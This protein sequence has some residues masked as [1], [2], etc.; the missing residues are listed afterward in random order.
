MADDV[1]I[2]PVSSTYSIDWKCADPFCLRPG[3]IKHASEPAPEPD[4]DDDLVIAQFLEGLVDGAQVLA[5][6]HDRHG[7]HVHAGMV[8]DGW[9]EAGPDSLATQCVLADGGG[10]SGDGT[11]CATAGPDSFDSDGVR[12]WHS[13]THG[14]VDRA[15]TPDAAAS[16]HGSC[17]VVGECGELPGADDGCV[18]EAGRR[19]PPLGSK[20]GC[21]VSGAT[22]GH[23]VRAGAVALAGAHV[24][25][26]CHGHQVRAGLVLGGWCEAGP[27]SL[28]T[29]C[30]LADGGGDRGDHTSC[31][32]AGPDLYDSDGV[33]SWHSVTHGVVDLACTSDAAASGHGSSAVVGDCG[34]LPGVADGCDDEAGRRAPPHGS[35][36]GCGLAGAAHGHLVHAGAVALAGAPV[37]QGH[38]AHAGMV[39]G[40]WCE[41]GP[42]S[43]DTPSV[44]V[45][46]GGNSG[47]HTS[48]ASAG[49]DSFSSDGVRSWQSVAHGV[50]DP[51]C[52]FDAAASVHGSSAVVG[53]CGELPGT[54]DGCDAVA[55]RR[56][57]PLGSQ[58]GCR[59]A[60]ASHGHHVHAG[61][62]MLAGAPDRHGHLVHA[63]MVLDGWR[64]VGPFPLADAGI[65]KL[66][67]GA[68]GDLTSCASADPDSF[69]SSDGVRPRHS[70]AHGAVDLAC[71]FDAAASDHGSIAV[72]GECGVLPGAF[73][74]CDDGLGRCAPPHGS[75][76]GD[77]ALLGHHVRA[78]AQVLAGACDR[79]GH[80]VHANLVLGGWCD[81]GSDSLAG[82]VNLDAGGGDGDD[83]TSCAAA[84]PDS[85]DSSDGVRLWHSVAH[86]DVDQACALDA[87]AS[88]HGANAV[89]GEC[90]D[91]P[92]G[93]DACD[94][95]AG[96]RAPP[97]GSQVG[98]DAHHG[99]HDGSSRRRWADTRDSTS[100]EDEIDVSHLIRRQLRSSGDVCDCRVC[101]GCTR[102][103]VAR[104]D[105]FLNE[106]MGPLT[107]RTALEFASRQSKAFTSPPWFCGFVP[108]FRE[109]RRRLW[110]KHCLAS[111]VMDGQVDDVHLV[112]DYVPPRRVRI[113]HPRRMGRG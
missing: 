32:T 81:A 112:D 4:A 92:G 10:N 88:V 17:A 18:D 51:T 99:R 67:D 65:L 75:Q 89:T 1:V 63:G 20:V 53:E 100:S 69:D 8:L 62:A 27:D 79:H 71:T 70:V 41:A 107:P 39:L 50:V 2:V 23:L 60:G 90:G 93:T 35:Q 21:E 16:G 19:A 44:L 25:L 80:P 33:R 103:M 37:R 82:A 111:D 47:D 54:A 76:V 96:R 91:L 13:V 66:G 61:E 109:T 101:E 5:G 83:I 110:V 26:G 56:A 38:H 40:G 28:A 11:S 29:P 94:G 14:V 58:V 108:C 77:G 105:G 64:A 74:V 68:G 104:F 113:R 87:A 73:D 34:D 3:A 12:S 97:Y 86:G 24:R 59:L 45:D 46:G 98:I 84:G 72:T 57:P 15:C 22:H 36:V 78:G 55:G 7:R 102:A 95:E 106:Q 31:A 6:A 43:L 49:P 42:D 85:F 48:C 30:V 52:T 9:C